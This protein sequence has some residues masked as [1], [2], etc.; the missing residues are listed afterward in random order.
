ME[1]ATQP[2]FEIHVNF[3]N[4]DQLIKVKPEDTS[5]GEIFY[6]CNIDNKMIT[7]IRFENDSWKQIWGELE[8]EKLSII[9]EAIDEKNNKSS[10]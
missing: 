6:T 8:E 2:E 5:D 9:G 10:L 3:E 7:Q 1:D 4:K